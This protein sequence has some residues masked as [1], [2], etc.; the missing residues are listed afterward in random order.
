M[1]AFT[2]AQFQDAAVQHIVARLTDRSGSRRMLLADEVGLGKTVVARG[3]IEGLMKGRGTP[4]TVIYLCSNVEIAEQ[5]RRKLDPDSG[6][7]VGRVMQLA[8]ARTDE[9]A[10]LRLYS[11]TPGTSLKEGTGLAWERRLLMYLLYRVYGLPVWYERWREFFKCG[12]G[13]KNWLKETTRPKLREAFARKTTT[14]L[15]EALAAAWRD[16]AVDGEPV[17]QAMQRIVSHFDPD[18]APAKRQRN[19]IIARLRAVMQR[20]V[21]RHLRPDLV[22]LDEVQRFREV[23]DMS[24]SVKHIATELFAQRAPVLILSA[25]PYRALTLGHEVA[26]GIASHHEDF[27][28]TLDFLFDGDMDTPGRIRTDFEAFGKR[29]KCQG[30]A[31]AVDPALLELKQALERNLKKV[32]CRTERNRYMLDPSKGI[33]D[34]SGDSG[35]LP[36]QGELEEFFRLY[37]SLAAFGGMGQVT[38]F[39]KSAPSLLTFLDSKYALVRRLRKDRIKVPRSLLTAGNDVKSLAD[40][41]HRIA[42]VIDVSLGDHKTPPR[43]WTAPTYTYYRDELYGAARP[44]KLLVFSGWRFVPKTV[45]IVTSRVATDRMGGELDNP[46]Q[47]LRFSDR[48]SFH[49][50]DACLPTPVL[51]AVGDVAYRAARSASHE[52]RAEDIVT[53][54]KRELHRRLEALGVSV[55][56]TGGDPTWRVAMRL[57]TEVDQ[58]ARMQAALRAWASET[59]GSE[60]LAPEERHQAWAEEWLEDRRSSLRIS[61]SRLQR[62]ALIAAFSPA[63]CVLRAVESTYPA[64]QVSAAL[65]QLAKLCL[66]PMRHYFNRPHVQQII[67]QHRLRRPWRRMC[68]G[69]E[70]GYTARVLV[71]SGDAHLQAVLDE[72]LYLLRHAIQAETVDNAVRQLEAVWALSQGT[73]RTNSAKGAGKSVLIETETEQHATHFALAFGEDVVKDVG[74]QGD[75]QKARKSIVREAFNSPFWPFV[76]ATTSVGQEGLDFHLYCRDVLHWNLPSNPVD[77]EQREGRLNRRDCLAVRASIA[78]DWPLE[79]SA[80]WRHH[81]ERNPWSTVF[82]EPMIHYEAQKY[83]HGLFPHWVYECRLQERTVRIQRHVPF[84]STSRDAAKYEGLKTRLALYR[85]VFGQ[86]NQEDLLDDLRQQLEGLEPEKRHKVLRRLSSYML[87]LSPIGHEEDVRHSV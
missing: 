63:N 83:M 85:L 44:R 51:A 54:A 34:A 43:L 16:T 11:F 29:L 12:A 68:T 77:L 79:Q 26:D 15:Q 28:R 49:V 87:N 70:P 52:Q 60:R 45:A 75:A 32:I 36:G 3:I 8:V 47:P 39:W 30:L 61:K 22:V 31:E 76:L 1:S 9:R 4:L 58:G 71:Y 80:A 24:A 27:F 57:E 59:R 72:Y 82:D 67:R 81:R 20:V 38:E 13:R 64:D 35:T 78:R 42:R 19:Q 46:T 10:R 86:V 6:P 41:N 74:D 69:G 2:R 84:F 7:S 33:D 21:L 73:P 5:N 56:P 37:D 18:D 25:T 55:V 40:R 50:F 23:L 66:G 65:E 17:V 14:T 48:R 53:A 62:L